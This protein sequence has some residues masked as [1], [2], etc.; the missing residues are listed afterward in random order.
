MPV[1]AGHI[2]ALVEDYLA[3]HPDQSS[4]LNPLTTLL[5]DGTD[6]TS[7]SQWSGHLTA[8]AV[9][10]RDGK[11]LVIA[12]RKY[13]G[14]WLQ[15]GGHLEPSDRTVLGAAMRELAEETGLRDVRPVQAGPVHIAVYKVPE[16]GEPGHLHFDVRFGFS[17]VCEAVVH[18]A[19]E[20]TAAAWIEPAAIE[21]TSLRDA[22]SMLAS[23][24]TGTG[25]AE[26]IGPGTDR[27]SGIP[28]GVYLI[29]RDQRGRILV[30]L[31]SDKVRIAPDTWAL[32]CGTRETWESA[33]AGAIREA[34][35]EVGITIAARDL[36]FVHMADITNSYGPATAVYF[37]AHRWSGQVGNREPDLCRELMW[38]DPSGPLPQPFVEHIELVLRNLANNASPC[39]FTEYGWDSYG[40]QP[41][42][43]HP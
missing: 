41:A 22:V 38:I 24:G 10:E 28:M 5:A 1:P 23:A 15:P 32:P 6:V 26:Q 37:T 25:T 27:R 16:G 20:A 18:N 3:A 11:I 7:Q 8:S 12:H 21:N 29:L 35:E 39:G 2:T 42:A 14:A 17:T 40:A 34:T 4:Y 33:T 9:V 19:A 43:S 13:G 36:T 30:T 31:R